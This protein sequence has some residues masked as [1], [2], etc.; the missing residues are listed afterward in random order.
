MKA[1]I[2]NNKPML[3]AMALLLTGAPAAWASSSFNSAAT[4]TYTIDSIVNQ[5]YPGDL[6][7]LEILGSFRQQLAGA[8]YAD[9][10]APDVY[11]SGDGAVT[12]DNPPLDVGGGFSHTFAVSGSV[13]DGSVYSHQ[14][15]RYGLAFTNTGSDSYAISLHLNY[16]LQAGANGDFAASTVSV[17]YFNSDGL[18]LSGYDEAVASFVAANVIQSGVSEAFSF[19]LDS[20]KA[21]GLYAK[22]RIDADLQA[23]PVPLPAAVWTFLAGLLGILGIK[24]RKQKTAE[25]V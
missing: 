2:R 14:L 23:A 13:N 24:K 9:G 10:D 15:G 1:F 21:E 20:G 19:L 12:A 7:G 17:D 3:L 5:T 6:S 16:A 4:L 18:L 25:S 22:V 11:I 8:A